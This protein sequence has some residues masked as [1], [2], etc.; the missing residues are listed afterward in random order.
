MLTTPVVTGGVARHRVIA[1]TFDDGPSPYTQ[2]I[3]RALTRLH[4]PATFFVVGQQLRYFSAG[5]RDEVRGHFEIGDHTE[6]HPWLIRLKPAAQYTQIESVAGSIERLGAPA[7][8]LF[9]P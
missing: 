3:V 2:Q 7:P 5:L 1:L 9:R 6:N 8:M 4:V